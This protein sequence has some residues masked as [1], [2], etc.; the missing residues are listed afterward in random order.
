MVFCPTQV[1][2]SV[3]GSLDGGGAQEWTVVSRGLGPWALCRLRSSHEAG[4]KGP[5]GLSS[6]RS[7]SQGDTARHEAALGGAMTK[8]DTG[9]PQTHVTEAEASQ[10]K[11]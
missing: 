1:R 3:R 5:K 2:V 7:H 9:L 6:T 8:F 4:A 11:A 10:K